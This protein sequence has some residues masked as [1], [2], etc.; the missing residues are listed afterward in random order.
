MRWVGGCPGEWTCLSRLPP[1]WP[2][3]K[4]Q[5]SETKAISSYPGKARSSGCPALT[6]ELPE[7]CNS[8]N[9]G[10][11]QVGGLLAVGEAEGTTAPCIHGRGESRI[12]LCHRAGPC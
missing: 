11:P 12:I 7:V 5:I 6:C 4:A 1:S 2:M 9:P 3:R 10:C 8:Q